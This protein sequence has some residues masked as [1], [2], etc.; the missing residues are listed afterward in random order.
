MLL[1]LLAKFN[2][3]YQ[4]YFILKNNVIKFIDFILTTRKKVNLKS[5]IY[6]INK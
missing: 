6:T 5:I 2:N 3:Q 4:I 1:L